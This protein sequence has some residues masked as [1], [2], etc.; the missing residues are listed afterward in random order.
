[1][2]SSYVVYN[3][4]RWGKGRAD[5]DKR[6][7]RISATA[8]LPDYCATA[9]FSS[10][11]FAAADLSHSPATWRVV[12]LS[13]FQTFVSA[14]ESVK[15][16]SSRSVKWRAASFHTSSGTGS[17]R[18]ATRVEASARARGARSASVKYGVSRH[19]DTVKRRSSVSPILLS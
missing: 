11:S 13:R 17:G 15:A 9:W 14:M 8:A 3:I 4:L 5:E 18:S 10:H 6:G 19:A 7:P 2:H 1:M 16:A 12:M